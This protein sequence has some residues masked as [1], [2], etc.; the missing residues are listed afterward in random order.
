MQFTT[1]SPGPSLLPS[2]VGTVQ[3]MHP[4]TGDLGENAA[5]IA[6]AL[7]GAKKLNSFNEAAVQKV[8]SFY[9]EEE[10]DM[11]KDGFLKCVRRLAYAYSSPFQR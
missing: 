6:D 2:R 8:P 1:I 11:S 10:K 4:G 7:E 5:E 9:E 3:A